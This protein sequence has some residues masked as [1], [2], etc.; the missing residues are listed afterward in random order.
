VIEGGSPHPFFTIGHSTRSVAELV[1]LLDEAHV[2]LVVDVRTVP[3]SLRHPQ[4]NRDTLPDALGAAGIDYGHLPALGGLRGKTPG[5]PAD[6]NAF[7]TNQSFHNYADYAMG[8]GAQ[9]GLARLL[10]I[11]R[12]RRCAIMC[13]EAVWWRCHRRIVADYLQ[14]RGETV[15]HILGPGSVALAQLTPAARCRADGTLSYP[16]CAA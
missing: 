16:A 12:E 10:E 6:T 11:G 9:T 14:S 3:R 13:A 1:E 4:F 2:R 5:V 8:Q 15:F 7:W